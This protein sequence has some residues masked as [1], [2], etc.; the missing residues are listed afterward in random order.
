[1]SVLQPSNFDIDVSN[2]S[3]SRN[4]LRYNKRR[5]SLIDFQLNSP[6]LSEEQLSL[7]N[8]LSSKSERSFEIE[9]N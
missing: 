8:E 2:Q 5:K 7:R 4:N 9:L 3:Q 1:M 6:L